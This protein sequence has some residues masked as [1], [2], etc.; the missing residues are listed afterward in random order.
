MKLSTYYPN[1]K[2]TILPT[3]RWTCYTFGVICA[4]FYF[5]RL[6]HPLDAVCFSH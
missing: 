1:S 4:K 2:A 6:D 3:E 5:K